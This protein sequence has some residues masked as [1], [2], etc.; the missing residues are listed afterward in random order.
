MT[1]L[2]PAGF[3]S[4]APTFNVQEGGDD[5]SAG[6]ASGF[7][8]MSYRGGKWHIKHRGEEH[9]LKRADGD[10]MASIELV[11]VRS[12]THIAKI[13][14]KDGYKEGSKEAPDCSSNNG[15]TPEANCKNKQATTCASCPQ[16][17]WGS[18]ITP[19]GKPGKAC[20]DSKRIVVV[21]LNDIANEMFGGAMLLRVPAASLNELASYGTRM[22][23]LGFPYY[24][25]GT[26]ISFDP[27]ANYPKFVFKEIRALTA[28]EA[29]QIMALRND[30]RTLR[31]L[32][33]A[34]EHSDAPMI[35]VKPNF[36]VPHDPVTGEVK[37]EP[38]PQKREYKKKTAAPA[39]VPAPVIE[40]EAEDTP[41]GTSF[42]DE[43]DAQMDALL[44]AA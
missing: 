37:A 11:I 41:T 34:S 16:N 36:D 40:V 5:L 4:L 7:A 39:P 6:I 1:S 23:S 33:E 26:R 2:V 15:V 17:A 18:R 32:S 31:I 38:A 25:I 20:S 9:L 30:P 14:Y 35:E 44:G 13:F 19:A 27:A 12:A 42:D 24:A 10:P 43:L 29:N 28:D 8:V 22:K 21:P 3:G